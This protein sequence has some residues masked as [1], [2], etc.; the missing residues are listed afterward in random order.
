MI[1]WK[2][3]AVIFLFT[4][5]LFGC[6]TTKGIE[7]KNTNEPIKGNAASFEEKNRES[8]G[9]TSNKITFKEVRKEVLPQNMSNSIN[10][11]KA[12]RGYLVY[13]KDRYYY[14]AVLSGKKNTGGYSIRVLSVE[15]NEGKTLITIEDKGPSPD[16][17]VTQTITYPYTVVEVTGVISNI[18]VQTTKGESFEK[19]MNAEDIY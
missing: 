19:I 10:N 8:Q 5:F 4:T 16:V 12:N 7:N 9:I 1:K 14:I 3:T 2:R 13:E 17:N 15:D 11:L 18:T 6:T